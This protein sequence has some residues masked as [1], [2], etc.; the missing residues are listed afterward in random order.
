MKS[1]E[2]LRAELD[3]KRIS[4]VTP[5]L[6]EEQAEI[7]GALFEEGWMKLDERRTA[8]LSA[9]GLVEPIENGYRL[10]NR[11]RAVYF[12]TYRPTELEEVGIL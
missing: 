5:E 11:G 10:T 7:M 9:A 4:G 8:P 3:L 6:L 2:A 1:L 12:A